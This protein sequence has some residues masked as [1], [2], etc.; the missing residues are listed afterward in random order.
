MKAAFK[1]AVMIFVTGCITYTPMNFRDIEEVTTCK[2]K[3]IADIRKN[4]LLAGFS[5]KAQGDDFISTDFKQTGGYATDKE[6]TRINVVKISDDQVKFKV[7]NRSDSLQSVPK[8]STTTQTQTSSK[9]APKTI[10][11]TT[12]ESQFITT[13]DEGDQTYYVELKGRYLQT[14]QEVC[15]Y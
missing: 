3:S 2:G 13:S 11:S 12:Q 14:K 1:I 5:I 15:G 7:V 4:L 9:V 10:E 6:L 8:Y